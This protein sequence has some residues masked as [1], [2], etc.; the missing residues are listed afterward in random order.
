MSSKIRH[1]NYTDITDMQTH[2]GMGHGGRGGTGGGVFEVG[3]A[4]PEYPSPPDFFL[5]YTYIF[6]KCWIGKV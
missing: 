5:K 1:V 3:L 6:K 2:K 4:D